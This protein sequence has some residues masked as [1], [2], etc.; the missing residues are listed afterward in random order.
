MADYS[1]MF[2][3]EAA[4]S[5]AKP[6]Q[7]MAVQF[8]VCFAAGWFFKYCERGLRGEFDSKSNGSGQGRQ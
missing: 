7:L 3:G 1:L 5:W 2:G 6:A 4:D 8:W